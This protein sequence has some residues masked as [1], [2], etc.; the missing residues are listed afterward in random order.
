MVL[1]LLVEA[2]DGGG[3]GV[4]II[5]REKVWPLMRFC[6]EAMVCL[7]MSVGVMVVF[8]VVLYVGF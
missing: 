4:R 3:L 7:F 8:A 2:G 5:S 1:L 6:S